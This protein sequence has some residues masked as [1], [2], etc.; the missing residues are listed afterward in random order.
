MALP[1][2]ETDT[3]PAFGTVR[4][5]CLGVCRGAPNEVARSACPFAGGR[6][7]QSPPAVPRTVQV[8][9]AWGSAHSVGERE[10]SNQIDGD[11]GGP[12]RGHSLGG[13]GAI[14]DDAV[15]LVGQGKGAEGAIGE[16]AAIY[17]AYDDP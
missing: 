12:Q 2:K 16:L 6:G 3:L 11:S 7:G 17:D 15:D 5:S 1:D 4:P 8:A 9:G 13:R 14:G 10:A